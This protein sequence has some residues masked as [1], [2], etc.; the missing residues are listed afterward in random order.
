[1]LCSHTMAR[2]MLAWWLAFLAVGVASPALASPAPPTHWVCSANG[3]FQ[4]LA[5]DNA[6]AAPITQAQL[7]CPLCMPIAL[8]GP[9][10]DLVPKVTVVPVPPP[11]PQAPALLAALDWPW[12]A[13]AP[14]L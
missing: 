1:M 4:V 2:L 11:T 10:L 5:L 12:Q 14:P 9:A 3:S 8:S 13:R 7:D 6:D